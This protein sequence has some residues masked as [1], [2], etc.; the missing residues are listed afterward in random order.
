MG[1]TV[2]PAN[3]SGD[4]GRTSVP[5]VFMLRS[6]NHCVR[7]NSTTFAVTCT[8]LMRVSSVRSLATPVS[9]PDFSNPTTPAPPAVL[10]AF[11][12]ILEL[13]MVRFSTVAK[14]FL[15]PAVILLT[16][17]S[18]CDDKP[19]GPPPPASPDTTA[20]DWRFEIDTLGDRNSFANKIVAFGPN[21]A[22]AAGKFL[23][24]T[25]P[26]DPWD[27][28]EYNVAHWD[29]KKW[30]LWQVVYPTARDGYS[31]FGLRNDH[32]LLATNR[33]FY[34]FEGS[35]WRSITIPEGTFQGLVGIWGKDE[36]E[37][38]IVGDNGT[39]TKWDGQVPI[40]HFTKIPTATTVDLTDIYGDGDVIYACGVNAQHSR[41]ILLRYQDGIPVV[42]DSSHQFGDP[43]YI[44]VWYTK[45][46]NILAVCGDWQRLQYNGWKTADS[47]W[48]VL[49]WCNQVRGSGLNNIW[50]V[51]QRMY[52]LHYNGST[53]RQWR[54][55]FQNQ[56]QLLGV[57]VGKDYLFA[58]G[59]QY[60]ADGWPRGIVIR[61]YSMR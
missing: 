59:I 8:G 5:P 60:V 9:D 25:N 13:F 36:R 28:K 43:K 48:S 49:P 40:G 50:W 30:T 21:D 37:F 61:G 27:S 51:G 34:I 23:E 47:N 2:K 32:I 41:S 14:I 57:A 56:G 55:Y 35:S 20:H 4:E 15:L 53:W 17:F 46:D 19:T 39:W 24:Y 18:R 45:R 1:E 54:N 22:W 11:N 26:N 38:H 44:S 58:S 10:S 7:E 6:G 31:I 42:V 29:G 33:G 3:A 52:L 12:G 16:T